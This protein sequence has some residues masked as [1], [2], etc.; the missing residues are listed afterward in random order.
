MPKITSKDFQKKINEDE[1]IK[2][3][4]SEAFLKHF[5][6]MV[7]KYALEYFVKQ[8]EIRGQAPY[9]AILPFI[10]DPNDKK[11]YFQD[12]QVL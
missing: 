11:D 6:K 9:H 2:F 5:N 7:K 10:T 1:L 3:R 4:Y 8:L 12:L